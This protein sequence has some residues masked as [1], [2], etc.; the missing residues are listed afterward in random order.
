MMVPITFS[1]LLPGRRQIKGEVKCS[2]WS[3][4]SNQKSSKSSKSDAATTVSKSAKQDVAV[5]SSV[6]KPK[7][8]K[9]RQI[10]S[11]GDSDEDFTPELKRSKI[12]KSATVRLESSPEIVISDSD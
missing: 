12:R 11:D 8:V 1:Y 2:L 6:A 7:A 9:K 4:T 5:K 3:K 10:E